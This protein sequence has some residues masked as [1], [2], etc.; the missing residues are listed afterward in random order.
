MH[1]VVK[2]LHSYKVFVKE[3]K[4]KSFFIDRPSDI[5]DSKDP[6]G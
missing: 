5:Q 1:T 2:N 6:D 4:L 3:I